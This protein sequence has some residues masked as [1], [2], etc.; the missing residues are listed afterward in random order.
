M[1]DP[2]RRKS[3]AKNAALIHP[4]DLLAACNTI[5]ECFRLFDEAGF[6]SVPVQNSFVS[7]CIWLGKVSGFNPRLDPCIVSIAKL[8]FTLKTCQL[9]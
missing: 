1:D 2:S 5:D 8:A 9:V 6:R 3:E 4:G 7:T